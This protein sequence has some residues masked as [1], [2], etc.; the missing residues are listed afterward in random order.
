[1]CLRNVTAGVFFLL[2]FPLL[3]Y[4]QEATLTGTITDS[5]GAVPRSDGDGDQ[6]RP[7]ATFLPR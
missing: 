7:P 1:M 3:V 4:G 6:T 5:T 2:A